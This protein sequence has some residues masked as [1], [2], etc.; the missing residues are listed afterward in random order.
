MLLYLRKSLSRGLP[1]FWFTLKAQCLR[2]TFAN[3]NTELNDIDY[4][5]LC[6]KRPQYFLEGAARILSKICPVLSHS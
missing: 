3:D 5:G 6:S 1:P 4:I 2:D